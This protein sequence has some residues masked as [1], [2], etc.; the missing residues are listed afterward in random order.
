MEQHTITLVPLRPAE[1]PQFTK[2]LQE[3]FSITIR[4][5]FG[6]IES[7][8]T[9]EEVQTA[10]RSK[11]TAI[12]HI[13][14]QNRRVGG[15]VVTINEQTQHNSLDLFFISPEHHSRG[16]GLAAW[17]AI[18]KAYPHTAVWE[19]VTPYFEERNIHFYVNKCGFQIVEFFNAHHMDPHG[20]LQEKEAGNSTPDIETYFR[21]EKVMQ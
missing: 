8:P 4:E 16:L 6:T 9:E 18:E 11:G 14:L 15:A 17:K 19:T 10:F 21:F 5:K 7:I 13:V 3:A 1:L 12:Y 2:N 20:P